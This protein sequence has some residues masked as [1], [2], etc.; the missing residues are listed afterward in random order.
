MNFV[1]YKQFTEWAI[2]MAQCI[3]NEFDLIVGIPR[4]GL[5][6]AT[7]IATKF[8]KPLAVPD[9]NTWKSPNIKSILICDDAISSGSQM[10]AAKKMVQAKYPSAAIYTAAVIKHEHSDVT[11]YHSLTCDPKLFEWNLAHVK[12]GRLA[13]DIDGVL[14]PDL[15]LGFREENEP[16]IYESH[17]YNSPPMFIPQYTINAIVSN[18]MEKWRKGTERWLNQVG[19]KYDELYLWNV[20]KP[21]A[22]DGFEIQEK[23][24]QV[25]EANVDYVFESNLNQAISIHQ[26]LN[27]PVLCFDRME[28]L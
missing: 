25:K 23:I 2:E 10:Y 17:I 19:I 9:S 18:R 11:F 20:D 21:E 1:S 16:K 28:M 14:C 6:L 22:R 13:C 24:R 4:A 8:G 27:I 26:T 15:P 5:I 12:Q 3:P 7:I